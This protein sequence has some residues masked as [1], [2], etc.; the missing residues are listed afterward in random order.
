METTLIAV[1]DA[2]V[3]YPAPLRDLLVELGSRDLFRARWSAEIH[4]EWMRNLGSD[5]FDLDPKRLKRTQ[6]LMDLHVTDSVVTGHMPLIPSL[7]LPDPDDRHV[8]AAAIHCHAS[9][10][11]T[12]N[13]KDF[14]MANL[15]QYGIGAQHPDPFLLELLNADEVAFCA[16]IK[17]VRQRLKNP[18]KTAE[19]YL[20]TL[21]QQE[22]AQTVERLREFVDLI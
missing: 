16:A 13:L 10:I 12:K 15:A 20:L 18:P 7:T 14:P 3:L 2:C 5:R 21:E 4:E 17:A 9:R 1:L 19:E 6:E 8:L 11:V 22:L